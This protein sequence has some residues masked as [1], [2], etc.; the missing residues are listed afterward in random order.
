MHPHIHICRQ[1]DARLANAGSLVMLMGGG[2]SAEGAPGK[3]EFIQKQYTR[4]QQGSDRRLCLFSRRGG[5]VL[6]QTVAVRQF[7]T[8]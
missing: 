4:C 6:N 8:H 1:H 2:Q 5:G 7:I 3:T